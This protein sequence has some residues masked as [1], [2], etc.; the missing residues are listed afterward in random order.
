MACQLL[1]DGKGVCGNSNAAKA[2]EMIDSEK[3]SRVQGWSLSK[4]LSHI[5][6]NVI[7]DPQIRIR[8]PVKYQRYSILC[9]NFQRGE[10]VYFKN[11]KREQ[12]CKQDQGKH[13]RGIKYFPTTHIV[14]PWARAHGF[15]CSSASHQLWLR[16]NL[17]SRKCIDFYWGS[18]PCLGF[19]TLPGFS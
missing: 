11:C 13:Q 9:L 1:Q 4:S 2:Q 14:G 17:C 6:K 12:N 5:A 3:Q 10:N 19:W 8:F 18:E 15:S 16:I 7:I